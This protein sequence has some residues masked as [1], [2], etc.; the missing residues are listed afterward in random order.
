MLEKLQQGVVVSVSLHAHMLWIST[1]YR[2]KNPL[3]N[4]MY[5]DKSL[6]KINFLK[7]KRIKASPLPTKGGTGYLYQQKD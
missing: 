3:I 7:L 1:I 5:F 2:G 4:A 6:L